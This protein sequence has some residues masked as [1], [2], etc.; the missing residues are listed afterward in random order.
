MPIS[1]AREPFTES[2]S[3]TLPRQYKCVHCLMM[4]VAEKRA[5][6]GTR[7]P[8]TET[9]VALGGG[10]CGLTKQLLPA[11]HAAYTLSGCNNYNVGAI[12]PSDLSTRV[13]RTFEAKSAGLTNVVCTW[14]DAMAIVSKAS[15]RWR[16]SG[17][18]V[19]EI[20]RGIRSDCARPFLGVSSS[21]ILWCVTS[22]E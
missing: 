5:P 20:I 14:A 1:S 7:M 9:A 8:P 18:K 22:I 16:P 12:S 17:E 10:R 19:R 6:S 3:A 15:E 4:Q 11:P 2:T 13:A 21:P